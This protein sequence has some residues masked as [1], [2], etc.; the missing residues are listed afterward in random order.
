MNKREIQSLIKK[1]VSKVLIEESLTNLEQ[2][3]DNISSSTMVGKPWISM[4]SSLE[5]VMDEVKDFKG[6]YSS[7]IHGPLPNT[8]DAMRKLQLVVQ[9]L[10]EI[11]PVIIGMSDIERKDI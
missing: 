10:G 6:M 1:N 8:D 2:Y 3:Q 9:L 4:V 5:A 11:K 7:K